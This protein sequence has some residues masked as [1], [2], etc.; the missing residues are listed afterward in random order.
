MPTADSFA[1]L[2]KGNGFS[3]FL[4]KVNVSNYA[5]WITLGGTQKGN[6][7]TNSEIETSFL[8]A[9]KIFW[10]TNQPAGSPNTSK[11]GGLGSIIIRTEG[12]TGD[13]LQP[14]DRAC[15]SGG[16]VYSDSGT[17]GDE[18]FSS[19]FSMGAEINLTIFRMYDGPTDDEDNFVGYGWSGIQFD[20]TVNDSPGQ[21]APSDAEAGDARSSLQMQSALVLLDPSPRSGDPSEFAYTTISGIPIAVLVSAY[22][23]QSAADGSSSDPLNASGASASASYSNNF[24]S[25]S[26]STSISGLDFYTY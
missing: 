16:A 20:A 2:G 6:T 23:D 25:G 24:C 11:G 10:N 15:R 7:P 22:A 4:G 12:S 19:S 14:I 3:F 21:Y 26:V 13:P 5:R 9:V 17:S 18:K 1:A 8:N